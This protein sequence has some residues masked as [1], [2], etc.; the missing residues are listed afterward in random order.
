MDWQIRLVRYRHFWVQI[1][2]EDFNSNKLLNI[3]AIH[4]NRAC[5]I[6]QL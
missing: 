4:W 1:E 5:K 2:E 6:D 3:A